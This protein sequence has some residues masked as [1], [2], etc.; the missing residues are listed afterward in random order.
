[1]EYQDG[2]KRYR[3]C[4]H[5]LQVGDEVITAEKAE[6]KTGNRMQLKNIPVGAQIYNVELEP[7]KG[8]KIVRGAG[9]SAK[10]LSQEEKFVHLLMPSSEVRKVPSDC[11]ASIGTV[12][13]PEHKF[14]DDKKAGKVRHLRRRP[15]VRGSAMGA[16]DH[17][18]GGGEG[19][20]PIGLKYPKTPTGKPALGVKTRK[21]KKSDKLI[22]RRRRKKKK[23]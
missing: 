17:P 13:F 3:I 7:G 1:M 15:V 12:S 21:K 20:A 9:T 22:I 23:K 11:F 5:G 8:G 19:R 6:V 4:P 18:H 14:I 2:E 10:I 16:H